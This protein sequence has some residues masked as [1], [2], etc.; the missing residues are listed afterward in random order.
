MAVGIRFLPAWRR[1][2]NDG[3]PPVTGGRWPG[4]GGDG[5]GCIQIAGDRGHREVSACQES[6]RIAGSRFGRQR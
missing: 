3:E 4:C 1:P 5:S 6:E 2:R